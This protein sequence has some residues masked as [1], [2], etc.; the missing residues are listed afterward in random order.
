MARN[1]ILRAHTRRPFL[2]LLFMPTRRGAKD[3]GKMLFEE[4]GK[5]S[6]RI[7]CGN[8]GMQPLVTFMTQVLL[9]NNPSGGDAEILFKS[10][11]H[12]SP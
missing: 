7:A 5:R 1:R 11:T 6:L 9:F 12:R 3:A 4:R 8:V 2:L 10:G